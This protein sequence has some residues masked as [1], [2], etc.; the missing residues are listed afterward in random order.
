MAETLINLGYRRVRPSEAKPKKK[1][2]LLPKYVKYCAI[3]LGTLE[4]KRK[5]QRHEFPIECSRYEFKKATE[6]LSDKIRF[7]G[8][9]N[10]GHWELK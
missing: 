5:V 2:E 6:I 7:V 8:N 1:P 4:K 3:V 9:G 10:V